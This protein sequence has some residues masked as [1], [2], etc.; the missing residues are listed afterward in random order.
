MGVAEV[1]ESRL[2]FQKTPFQKTTFISA[3]TLPKLLSG[4]WFLCEVFH[5]RRKQFLNLLQATILEGEYIYISEYKWTH[6][7]QTH[8]VRGSSVVGSLLCLSQGCCHHGP[9]VKEV[10]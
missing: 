4:G 8:I 9:P 10:T 7:I 6:V 3:N 5:P 1:F 2:I